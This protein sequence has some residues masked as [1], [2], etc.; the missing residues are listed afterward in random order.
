MTT[1]SDP[2]NSFKFTNKNFVLPK[3]SSSLINTKRT[4][5]YMNLRFDQSL[6]LDYA[7][8]EFAYR[9]MNSGG[10]IKQVDN[11]KLLHEL[12][13]S[14]KTIF[15]NYLNAPKPF[16]I[17][18]QIVNTFYLFHK[19]KYSLLTFILLIRLI[20]LPFKILIFKDNLIRLKYYLYGIKL[21]FQGLNS[22][23]L[24]KKK[25]MNNKI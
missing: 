16:R 7:D 1:I 19:Y 2:K 18:F 20:L 14:Y 21:G 8:W 25:I 5:N 11:I 13:S 23:E 15:G 22:Y 17:T 12:G 24:M 6:F 9:I 4:R 10:L 3:A